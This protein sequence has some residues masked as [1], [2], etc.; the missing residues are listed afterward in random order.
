MA[1][2]DSAHRDVLWDVIA[3]SRQ[4]VLATIGP[5]GAP[6]LSN[7]YYVPDPDERLI[8]VSTTANRVKG[9]NLER[10]AHASLYVPGVD[11][12]NYSVAEGEM[13]LAVA[14]ELGDPATD[15]LHA[16]HSVFNGESERPAFDERMISDGRMVARLTVTRL[17][18]LVHPSPSA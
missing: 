4:G 12:F 1:R 5:G 16:V 10:D 3:G 17:Y 2:K 18:G 9:R 11:F 13:T 7:V 6:H 14:K 8:R 15:E